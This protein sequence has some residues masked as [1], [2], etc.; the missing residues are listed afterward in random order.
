MSLQGPARAWC[1]ET[2]F[3]FHEGTFRVSV[4]ARYPVGELEKQVCI[5]FKSKQSLVRPS[6]AV[7]A[8][9]GL[10]PGPWDSRPSALPAR[11]PFLP[12]GTMLTLVCG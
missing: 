7:G 8:E 4:L 9:L 12:S 6:E 11:T 3:I 1:D 10:E 5:L 2:A